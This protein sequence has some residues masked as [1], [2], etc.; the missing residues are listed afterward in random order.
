MLTGKRAG[1]GLQAMILAAPGVPLLLLAHRASGSTANVRFQLPASALPGGTQTHLIDLNFQAR[2]SEAF[3]TIAIHPVR[4]PRLTNASR[5]LKA[6]VSTTDHL[7]LESNLPSKDKQAANAEDDVPAHPPPFCI[8]PTQTSAEPAEEPAERAEQLLTENKGVGVLQEGSGTD[9]ETTMTSTKELNRV[10]RPQ[11]GSGGWADVETYVQTT[12]EFNGNGGA[13]VAPLGGGTSSVYSV[14]DSE[15]DEAFFATWDA[16][17]RMKHQ[18]HRHPS[19]WMWA[20]ERFRPRTSGRK[21]LGMA[22]ASARGGGVVQRLL[23]KVRNA[24][25]FDAFSCVYW[26][27]FGGC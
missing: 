3:A 24:E 23:T 20:F 22:K 6:H 19:D 16:D 15:G 10:E 21:L 9:T 11:E 18:Q 5:L 2:R 8:V 14:K 17:T 25:E 26:H 1:A 13:F 7:G 4:Q 12:S 27:L